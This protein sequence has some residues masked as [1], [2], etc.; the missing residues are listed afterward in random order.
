MEYRIQFIVAALASVA[1]LAGSIFTF[2]LLYRTGFDM[3]GWTWDQAMLV[4]GLFT[5]LDGITSAL[6]SPNLSRI[7]G[8]VQTGTLDFVLLKPIDA[9][10]WLSLRTFSP[11]GLPN[12][13]L[14]L[15][16]LVVA[17]WRL[18]LPPIQVALAMLPVLMGVMILYSLWFM[19]AT[20][21]I[22]LVRTW[23]ATEVLRAVLEAGRYPVSAYPAGYRVI[24]TFVLPVAFLTTVPAEAMLGRASATWLVA[25]LALAV[26]MMIF[27]RLFWRFALRFYSSASS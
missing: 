26:G 15:L 20:T 12:V 16:V 6:L 22:W 21:T 14:G 5:L 17:S 27:A 1:S 24:F 8:H 10:I 18:A 23:N 9:Q 25:E 2:F 4:L 11:W 19:V 3:N 13:A 7:V